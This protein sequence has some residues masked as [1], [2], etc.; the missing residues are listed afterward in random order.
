MFPTAGLPGSLSLTDLLRAATQDSLALRQADIRDTP[1]ALE[2]MEP[3]AL[4]GIQGSVLPA[5]EHQVSVG[6][7]DSADYLD[8]RDFVVYLGIRA[9]VD[10]QDIQG[11]AV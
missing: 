4:A 9:S 6:T 5:L 8:I 7:L 3:Q 1:E 10:C 2:L 11:S